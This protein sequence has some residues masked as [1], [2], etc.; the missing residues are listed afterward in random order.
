M[1]SILK[2]ALSACLEH[3]D[4]SARESTRPS[5]VPGDLIPLA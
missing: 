4:P 2:Y 1:K 5:S 3:L